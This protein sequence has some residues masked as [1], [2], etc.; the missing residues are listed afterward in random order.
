LFIH[1]LNNNKASNII[2][3]LIALCWSQWWKTT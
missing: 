1:Q 3:S 2:F